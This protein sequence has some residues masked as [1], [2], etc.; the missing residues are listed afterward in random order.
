MRRSPSTL[1]PTITCRA[2]PSV[3]GSVTAT[4]CI[5][6]LS[7]RRCTRCRT[8]ASDSPTILASAAYDMRPSRC[9]CS[10]IRL[11]MSSRTGSSRTDPRHGSAMATESVEA[12]IARDSVSPSGARRA[13][14]GGSLRPISRDDL[15]RLGDHVVAQ[16]LAPE[17]R[18]RRR[19]CSTIMSTTPS[20]IEPMPSTNAPPMPSSVVS[21]FS[22]SSR[23]IAGLEHRGEQDQPAEQRQDH[24]LQRRLRRRCRSRCGT[25]GRREAGQPV[26]ERDEQA[27]R[28][29]QVG[30]GGRS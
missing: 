6:P 17:E 14:H 19:C 29:D 1:T 25:P 8:A 5:T 12:R 26:V 24:L 22:G 20:S 27:D 9:R 7:S 16:R 18:R 13:A 30:Q 11:L 28:Q 10:M 21:L 15:A 23:S 4:I 2:K 3:S